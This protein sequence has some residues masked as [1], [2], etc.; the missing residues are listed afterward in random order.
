MKET[1][2]RL[3]DSSSLFASAMHTEYHLN[4][5][6]ESYLVE[7][8]IVQLI[9]G[10]ET[11]DRSGENVKVVYGK[12]WALGCRLYLYT[13]LRCSESR[14]VRSDVLQGLIEQLRRSLS[15]E[16]WGFGEVY[17]SFIGGKEYHVG[18][19]TKNF[20]EKYYSPNVLL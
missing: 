18:A 3:K 6:N 15:E 2:I 12:S 17:D 19:A 7:S 10:F 1:F 9:Q 5:H 14:P 11:E 8:R 13:V 4:I 16:F 20:H